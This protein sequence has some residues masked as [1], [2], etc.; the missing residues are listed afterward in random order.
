MLIKANSLDGIPLKRNSVQTIVT[1][2]PYF[3]RRKYGDSDK[4]FGAGSLKD[5]LDGWKKLGYFIH[6]TL[7]DSGTFWLNIGDTGSKTGGSGG[8]YKP[9]GK[10]QN[11]NDYRP[12]T[13]HLPQGS[14]CNVP[15]RVSSIL[16][17]LTDTNKKHLFLLRAEIIWN[18]ELLEV[19]DINYIRR[20][21]IQHEIIYLFSKNVK[22]VKDY[23]FY[24]DR[25]KEQG[26]V[27]TFPPQRGKKNSQ[28]PFPDELAERCILPSTDEDDIVLDIFSGSGTTV[29]VAERLNRKGI[30]LELYL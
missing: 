19:C 15:S 18:K 13:T 23:K 22:S 14:W 16:S 27:W 20:P 7:K 12:G 4:E 21:K 24:P 28:A 11:K 8:D 1:S 9:G 10:Q 30:G 25:L 2:P 17:D 26:T 5:Y 6:A 29:S 3:G